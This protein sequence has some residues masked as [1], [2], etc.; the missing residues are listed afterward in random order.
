M[1]LGSITAGNPSY[2]DLN[3]VYYYDSTCTPP[4]LNLL[5]N[6]FREASKLLFN[7]TNGQI[8]IRTIR[9]SAQSKDQDPLFDPAA[10]F[11]FTP[12]INAPYPWS[13]GWG[14]MGQPDK[15][16][17]F[18]LCSYQSHSDNEIGF[19]IVHELGHYA[20]SLRDEYENGNP[21]V[22]CASQI[23]R[24]ACIMDGGLGTNQ[25][26]T[27]WCTKSGGGLATDHVLN[28]ENE[29]QNKN[30]CSCWETLESFL[31]E[32]WNITVQA[33][34]S[35]DVT[36]P[37]G[38]EEPIWVVMGRGLRMVLALDRSY[39]MSRGSKEP[40]AKQAAG[41]FAALC[42]PDMGESIGVVSFSN[43]A[44]INF[45]LEEVT[46]H[47]D[48]L[49]DV[50]N[51]ID[52]IQLENMTALGDGL[53]YSLNEITTVSRNVSASEAIVLLSD[54][55][56]NF[57]TETP[58]QVLPD[59]RARGVRVFSIGLGDPLDSQ[60]P[61]DEATL[62]DIS[63]QTGGTYFHVMDPV[64]LS[65][66]YVNCAA[67]V[68]GMGSLPEAKGS[69]RPGETAVHEFF[70]DKFSTEVTFVLHWPH[71][72]RAFQL[73]LKPSKAKLPSKRNLRGKNFFAEGSHYMFYRVR[74][75]K[76]GPWKV[77]VRRRKEISPEE[78][79]QSLS[80]TAQVMARAPGLSCC[81]F[82]RTVFVKPMQEV[83][84]KAVVSAEAI[85][86]ARAEVSAVIRKPKG[87][88][89]SLTLHDNGE[90]KEHQDERADDGVYSGIFRDTE[91]EGTYQV[92]IVVNNL[93]GVT[94]I[95]DEKGADWKPSPV[96]PF[97]RTSITTFSV[98]RQHVNPPESEKNGD[99]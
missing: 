92:Q 74:K 3:V 36:L 84:L 7:S 76:P 13:S 24:I 65:T 48:S 45:Q 30:Q 60:Y 41:L 59:L 58:S 95:P 96:A 4:D 14:V 11:M 56:N 21:A 57:G 17:T 31:K 67:A 28:P 68:R 27:E 29:Q 90:W 43:T 66:I 46:S 22:C 94:A 69:L 81:V 54:G 52:S 88:P 79:A 39:S 16:M 19:G 53:R 77:I 99:F 91:L 87:D 5:W 61:L 18:P 20:F 37:P 8:L 40:L 55:V 64:A 51:A 78:E 72:P 26:R 83:V 82:P 6:P 62:L 25:G 15:C 86:V 97:T 98:G 73:Q 10:D 63:S 89:V 1:G 80:Y 49:T 32:K 44:Q 9:V 12:L 34:T 2:L 42:K 33:P 50:I 93:Q 38:W 47:P 23:S 70:V 71:P 35:V 75:P 85:P